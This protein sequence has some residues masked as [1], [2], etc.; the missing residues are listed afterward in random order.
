MNNTICEFSSDPEQGR[1]G[2]SAVL[3]EIRVTVKKNP[4]VLFFIAALVAAMLFAGMH[5]AARIAPTALPRDN[6]WAASPQTSSFKPST[7]RPQ[8]LWPARQSRSA[9]FLATYCGPCKL[10]MP[11]F[12]ELQKEYARKV[13]RS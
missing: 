12:V 11:W 9:Q 10:E 13:F 8:T 7:A 6:S 2:G 5:M 4:L 3:P 1:R